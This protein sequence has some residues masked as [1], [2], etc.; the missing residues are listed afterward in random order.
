MRLSDYGSENTMLKK[1]IEALKLSDNEV[2]IPIRSVIK[3]GAW[4]EE[5]LLNWGKSSQVNLVRVYNFGEDDIGRPRYVMNICFCFNGK[6]SL[7]T[8]V[9]HKFKTGW[10][11][12]DID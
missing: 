4:N 10:N 7:K 11:L 1:E 6:L 3:T 8:F 2:I 9:M 5:R 12:V